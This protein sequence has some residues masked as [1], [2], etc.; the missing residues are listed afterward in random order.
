LFPDISLEDVLEAINQMGQPI[1]NL[2]TKEDVGE[3]KTQLDTVTVSFDALN[4]R[5]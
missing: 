5:P 4:P 3:L 1:E 2:A